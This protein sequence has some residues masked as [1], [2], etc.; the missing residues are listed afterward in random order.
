MIIINN[1]NKDNIK[2]FSMYI[3]SGEIV[4]INDKDSSKI[5]KIY[6]LLRGDEDPD[7]GVIR[8]LDK[9]SYTT[10]L[11]IN[12]CGFVF[13][14]NILLADRTLE[15]NLEYIIKIKEIDMKDHINRIRRI[16][17]IV[18]L[19]LLSGYKP[20]ELLKPQLL[21]ANIAQAILNYPPVLVLEDPL[22]ELDEVNSQG[23]IR[24]LK[25]LNKFSMTIILCTSSQKLILGKEARVV[26]LT[27]NFSEKKKGYYA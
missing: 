18:D 16:L 17:D 10:K 2:D 14:K 12:L 7:K 1:L 25:R 15:E 3:K 9:G 24:L 19:K 4:C 21:R 6:K 5:K 11:P 26:K 8:Y 23:I 22:L 20:A 13:K 27:N